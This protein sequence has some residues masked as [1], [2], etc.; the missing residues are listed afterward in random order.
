MPLEVS[1]VITLSTGIKKILRNRHATHALAASDLFG[2][3]RRH[4]I[5]V[6]EIV[7]SH[8]DIDRRRVTPGLRHIRSKRAAQRRLSLPRVQLIECALQLF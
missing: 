1:A 5:N 3:V 6:V 2:N 7:A 4:F 8:S